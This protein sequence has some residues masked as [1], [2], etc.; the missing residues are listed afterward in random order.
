[1]ATRPCSRHF[2]CTTRP[3]TRPAGCDVRTA[4]LCSLP[5]PNAGDFRP[6]PPTGTNVYGN[7]KSTIFP[8]SSTPNCSFL[9]LLR[10][11]EGPERS[12]GLLP[13]TAHWTHDSSNKWM[14]VRTPTDHLRGGVGIHP[15]LAQGLQAGF[16]P[17]GGP[18]QHRW[19]RPN[20]VARDVPCL[21]L[22]TV[23]GMAR[24]SRV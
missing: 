2:I 18:R 6:N 12:W 1:M 16:A 9:L 22:C 8:K 3:P 23:A 4:A 19:V 5:Q 10:P 7:R 14:D 24:R 17:D 11:H 15:C 21:T 13:R 20:D